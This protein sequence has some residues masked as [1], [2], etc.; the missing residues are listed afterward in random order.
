MR[1]ALLMLVVVLI[2][3]PWQRKPA[4]RLPKQPDEFTAFGNLM[5]DVDGFYAELKRL[6]SL[7]TLPPDPSAV[8]AGSNDTALTLLSR[9]EKNRAGLV[10]REQAT[11]GEWVLWFYTGPD[12]KPPALKVLRDQA[13][14]GGYEIELSLGKDEASILLTASWVEGRYL[15]LSREVTLGGLDSEAR[16]AAG[17]TQWTL[18]GPWL[19]YRMLPSVNGPYGVVRDAE[20][21]GAWHGA[22]YPQELMAPAV[23]AYDRSRG[24]LIAVADDHPRK[25]DRSYS[26]QWRI[27]NDGSAGALVRL[28]HSAYDPTQDR[29]A[30]APMASGLPLRDVIVIEPFAVTRH[31]VDNTLVE[32]ETSEVIG[33]LADFVHA[34]HFRPSPPPPGE[35][36][37]WTSLNDWDGPK[38]ASRDFVDRQSRLWDVKY[39]ED[40]FLTDSG[41]HVGAP[42]G[43]AARD[44]SGGRGL[45]KRTLRFLEDTAQAGLPVFAGLDFLTVDYF[46]WYHATRPGRIA[47]DASGRS[48]DKTQGRGIPLIDVRDPVAA[49]WIVRKMAVDI[50]AFPQVAGYDLC[51]VTRFDVQGQQGPQGSCRV[52]YAAGAAAVCLRTA[53]AVREVRPDAMI[54]ADGVTLALPAFANAYLNGGTTWYTVDLTL[55]DL[56]SLD[57]RQ[58]NEVLRQVFGVRPVCCFSTTRPACQVL[59]TTA[60]VRGHWL[61]PSLTRTPGFA[62]YAAHQPELRASGGELRVI[63]SYPESCG[64]TAGADRPAEYSKLIAV[65][66]G[67][68]QSAHTVW[69]AFVG[70]AAASVEVDSRNNLTV[71]WQSGGGEARGEWTER[72]PPGYWR[73]LHPSPDAVN[74]GDV[75]LIERSGMQLPPAEGKGQA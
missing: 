71:R 28:A 25:L 49:A 46:N 58:A 20:A 14:A 64:Y 39:A 3:C 17:E 55:E 23:A 44:M 61:A 15:R 4:V 67:D 5:H 11:R 18:D 30:D 73:I 74:S 29:F 31:S 47:S 26:V 41:N 22:A 72:L 1:W 48:F 2:G 52:S 9:V 16:A 43:I 27:A 24:M 7:Y 62:P 8:T 21:D 38:G 35:D 59:G 40:W 36:G 13:T 10:L 37:D 50:A 54:A 32:A 51:N 60:S 70:I 75:V 56:P 6:Q 68:W 69:I 66:P 53:E 34:F 12:E 33:H 45:S 42:V 63:Y 65:L 57:Y 19:P